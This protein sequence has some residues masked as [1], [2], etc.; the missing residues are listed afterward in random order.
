MM[1]NLKREKANG[2]NGFSTIGRETSLG[3]K[4][5]EQQVVS[6]RHQ[7]TARKKN[8]KIATWNVRSL[9]VAGR[10]EEVKEEMNRLGIDILG[11]CETHWIGNGKFNSDNMMILYSGGEQHARGVGFIMSKQL[12]KS[13][14]GC[15]TISDRVMII[16]LKGNLLI[17]TSFKF[18]LQLVCHL[19]KKLRHST[20]NST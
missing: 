1:K 19:M 8:L 20:L 9:F 11:V 3:R 15:W 5:Y 6:D 7:A 10:L 4:H 2:V 14:I 12:S 13:L 17:F 18:M 16:K